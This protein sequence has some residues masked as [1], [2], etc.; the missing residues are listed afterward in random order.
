MTA[1]KKLSRR[2]AIKLLGAAAGATVLANL[3]SKW[4]TPELASG[5]LPVHAQTSFAYP[6]AFRSCGDFLFDYGGI[7][8]NGVV[9][10]DFPVVIAPSDSGIELDY[11][12]SLT[13]ASGSATLL[14]A[15]NGT[16]STIDGTVSIPVDLQITGFNWHAD[17]GAI[18]SLGR[19]L[20]TW[21]FR[22]PSLGGGNCTRQI[23]YWWHED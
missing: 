23:N 17:A 16:V 2:D 4:S 21:V 10:W 8:L 1:P 3:P 14:S 18:L 5:V 11:S 9:S 19:V 12:I 6:Y 22:D 15:S 7:A 20:V 13:I